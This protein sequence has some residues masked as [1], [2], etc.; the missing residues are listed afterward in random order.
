M[1]LSFIAAKPLIQKL[2]I[3]ELRHCTKW[4]STTLHQFPWASI[5]SFLFF[6]VF[7]TRTDENQMKYFKNKETHP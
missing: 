1:R 2:N 7:V 6:I 4:T 3:T 5:A